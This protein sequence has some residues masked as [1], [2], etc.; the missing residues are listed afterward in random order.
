MTCCKNHKH[1]AERD[2]DM[3]RHP[4]SGRCHPAGTIK[5]LFC[6]KGQTEERSS[7]G[8]ETEQCLFFMLILILSVLSDCSS[9]VLTAARLV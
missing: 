9:P 3:D 7:R 8:R 1:E 2:P 5:L 6:S 4:Y